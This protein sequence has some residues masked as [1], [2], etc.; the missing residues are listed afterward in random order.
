MLPFIEEELG[1]IVKQLMEKF[2]K[3]SVISQNKYLSDL[4]KI[5]AEST[6]NHVSMKKV[7]ISFAANSILTK[8]KVTE[9]K[10]AEFKSMASAEL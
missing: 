4:L 6:E 8:L 7:V 2:I 1:K 9:A 5:D 3:Q 10:L